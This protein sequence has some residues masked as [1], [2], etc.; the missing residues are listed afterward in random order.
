MNRDGRAGIY[1]LV[2]CNLESIIYHLSSRYLES[3]I[4][5]QILK[6]S[7]IKNL[8]QTRFFKPKYLYKRKQLDS[9]KNRAV[10]GKIPGVLAKNAEFL[11][12]F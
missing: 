8:I 1:H 9:V 2:P 10:L 3:K 5:Y 12:E 7:P 4:R 11:A 6:K